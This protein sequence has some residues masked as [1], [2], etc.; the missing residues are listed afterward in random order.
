MRQFGTFKSVDLRDKF[1]MVHDYDNFI[2]LLLKM[3]AYLPE[4]RIS[5]KEAM[6]HPYFDSVRSKWKNLA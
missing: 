5:A 4:R 3:L 6:K 1:Y 2:D